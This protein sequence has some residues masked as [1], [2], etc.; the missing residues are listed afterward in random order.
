MTLSTMMGVQLE[1]NKVSSALD[2]LMQHARELNT[3]QAP[4]TSTPAP[5]QK[6]AKRTDPRL[7]ARR[8]KAA[9][10]QEVADPQRRPEEHSRHRRDSESSYHST[11]DEREMDT[12][13]VSIDPNN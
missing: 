8:Q 5:P 12:M 4:S 10:A 6:T 2:G 7:E 11:T 9:T 13:D 1:E 3:H